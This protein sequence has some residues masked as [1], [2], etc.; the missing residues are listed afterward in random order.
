MK[1]QV[2]VSYNLKDALLMIIYAKFFIVNNVLL[3]LM[4]HRTILAD[5]PSHQCERSIKECFCW[6]ETGPDTQRTARWSI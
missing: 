4:E 1:L 6:N 3:N 5:G 2:E